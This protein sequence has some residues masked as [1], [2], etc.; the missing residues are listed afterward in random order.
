MAPV[1]CARCVELVGRVA[2][3]FLPRWQVLNL[4]EAGNFD[5]ANEKFA[6]T[7]HDIAAVGDF[8]DWYTIHS[9]LSFDAIIHTGWPDL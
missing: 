1:W 8:Y 5:Y 3:E 2:A 7:W 6:T 9:E 4:L